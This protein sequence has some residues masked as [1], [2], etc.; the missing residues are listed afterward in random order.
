[1]ELFWLGVFVGASS[2]ISFLGLIEVIC[3]FVNIFRRKKEDEID[4]RI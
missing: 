4:N 3:M 1:M 2:I